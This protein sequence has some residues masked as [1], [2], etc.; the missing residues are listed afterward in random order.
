MLRMVLFG[1]ELRL[2]VD[3]IISAMRGAQCLPVRISTILGN[4]VSQSEQHVCLVKM[5]L[6][7]SWHAC[8]KNRWFSLDQLPE[9]KKFDRL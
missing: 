9:A 8:N 4:I 1:V 3:R 5:L 6:H 7:P 2:I